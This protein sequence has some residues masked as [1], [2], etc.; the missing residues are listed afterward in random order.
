MS[1]LYLR[2]IH[3][4]LL[5]RA[6][7]RSAAAGGRILL[8]DGPAGA[9]PASVLDA[10]AAQLADSAQ[11]RIPL[12]PWHAG[13]ADYLRGLLPS[14]LDAHV[15]LIDDLHH[16]DQASLHYLVSRVR[17]PDSTTTVIA[18]VDGP[19]LHHLATDVL[20]LPPLTFAETAGYLQVTTGSRI[21]ADTVRVIHEM[22]RGLP[23]FIDD[24]V[25][26]T[27]AGHLA[28]PGAAVPVPESWRTRW[29][30][31]TGGLE[32]EEIDRLV[33]GDLNVPAAFR[34]GIV[35]SVPAPTRTEL[36]FVDP[37][38]AAVALSRR[39][40]APGPDLGPAPGTEE[41]EARHLAR[42]LELTARLDLPAAEV[43][44][45]ECRGLVDPLEQDSLRGYLALNRGRRRRA[46]VFLSDTGA[47]PRHAARSV[48]LS[49]A[50][51]DLTGM[52]E[53]AASI[54]VATRDP[55]DVRA[56]MEARILALIAEAGL[57]GTMPAIDLEPQDQLNRQR[58]DMVH[59]WLSLTF[60][61]P[62]TAR[63]KLQFFPGQSLSIGLWQDAWLSRT[64]YVLGEWSNAAMIV[65][66][67]LASAEV[68]AMH[69]LEP[70]L[71]WT[72][73]QIAAMQG[74]HQLA[75]DY[76]QRLT[77]S[78]NAFLLQSLPAA[79]GRMIVSATNADLPT[80][81]RAGELLARTVAST[82]TQHPG[83]WP[84]ED[85]YA[86]TLI[87]AGR[88]EQADEV[89]TT[90]EARHT[91]SGLVSLMAK[92]AV[93]RA[94]IQFQRGETAAGLRTF[95]AAVEAIS[96]TPMPAYEARIL[97][98]YGKVLRRHGRRSRADEVLSQ[99]AELFA[100]MGATVMVGR[101]LTERRI[102]GIS[103]TAGGSG[104]GTDNP[105]G[106]TPQEEQI[107][108]RVAE[109]ASNAD[110][111]RELTLSTKTVEYHLTRVYRKLGVS[112][113]SQLRGLL[114]R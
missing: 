79:M 83:F 45:N 65:E 43:H 61:D 106:L 32:Q 35:H 39:P 58:L 19:G 94:T 98:E 76:L 85:V 113:R 77:L 33:A 9:N 67:G 109:G 78:E 52:R 13:Q 87:R 21:P 22:T 18:S 103:G 105:H 7:I 71:L 81:L 17:R 28:E 56:H 15:L 62:L 96:G 95:E 48:L 110:V 75:R 26:A 2:H 73:V 69:L 14:R 80:A 30:Q 93:P 114:G 111:A 29:A 4:R 89:I 41:Y 72:G 102:G 97:F 25:A 104:A 51:W 37:R 40:T 74:E 36:R 38:D 100:Q 64:L 42:A 84:W 16:A 24:L 3:R 86:Q 10:L 54:S 91:P 60:D 55:R 90:A 112:S 27:P 5:D 63:E 46:Q 1:T 66:R 8:V 44:L 57:S 23:T 82:D 99:A 34:A 6:V 50:D 31:M 53:K 92:N 59:G 20:Q 70:M 68:H 88:I 107:A 12:F 108:V 49:L 101:C 47:L 11:T